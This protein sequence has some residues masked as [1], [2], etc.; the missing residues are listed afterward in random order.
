MKLWS[1]SFS[2]R[3]GLGFHALNNE[4]SEGSNLMQPRRIDVG[5]T[6][7]DGISGEIVRHHILENFVNICRAEDI[8]ILPASAALHPDRGQLGIRQKAGAST[9]LSKSNP[10][11]LYKAVRNAV[12]SCAVLDVGGFLAPFSEPQEAAGN[13]D[14]K[15]KV[16]P[17]AEF[18][19]SLARI[20]GKSDGGPAYTVKRDSVF[21]VAWLIS[22]KPQDLAITQHSA[23]RP[24]GSQSLFSQTMRSNVYAGVIRAE[25]HR[26]GTDDYW[27]LGKGQRDT[28]DSTEQKRRQLALIKAIINFIAAPTGAKV[29]GWAPHS[30]LT[31][32]VVL[33][34]S[35]RT[36]P[37]I[38][39]ISIE[40]GNPDGPVKANPG[41]STA[42]KDI[43]DQKTSWSWTFANPKELLGIVEE[44]NKRLD[45]EQD[46]PEKNQAQ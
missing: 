18:E 30:F 29:A 46:G 42:M 17:E 9:T 16:A 15:A 39:P 4:G 22:E 37:F 36:A 19:M 40:C 5:K 6:T 12:N 34:T 3:L 21:D 33:L 23:Y 8:S 38:S 14:G 27:Y 32:G 7:Y 1:I 2:Y 28:I 44:V 24:S 25:L 20:G 10:A 41:Y 26:I 11:D 31:D 45:G 35:D 13:G 43:A